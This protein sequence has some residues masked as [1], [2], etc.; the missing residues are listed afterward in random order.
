MNT[1]SATNSAAVTVV[2]LGVAA[3][4]LRLLAQTFNPPGDGVG[5]D[6]SVLGRT[7]ITRCVKKV[8]Q[9]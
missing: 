8:A 9:P 2:A 6:V 1:G 4:T 3:G 5:G 7:A